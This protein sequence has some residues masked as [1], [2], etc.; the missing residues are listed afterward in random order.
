MSYINEPGQRPKTPTAQR[1]TTAIGRPKSQSQ[2][3]FI[4]FTENTIEHKALV[5]TY[6]DIEQK[7]ETF[8]HRD[9]NMNHST[10]LFDPTIKCGII[11][12]EVQ[13]LKQLEGVGIADGSVRYGPNENPNKAGWENI[14]CYSSNGYVTHLGDWIDTNYQLVT[15]IRLALEL[16]MDAKPRTLTFFVNDMELLDYVIDIPP[17]V[18][19]WAYISMDSCWTRQMV[20]LSEL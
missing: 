7:G 11:K 20:K 18:R 3:Q 16:N 8:G 9:E 6:R 12:F 4:S 5:P 15:G 10:I 19:F 13:N 2:S 17:S 14:V 1:S